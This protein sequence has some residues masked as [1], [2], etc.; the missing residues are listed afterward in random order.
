MKFKFL[1][2]TAL[3]TTLVACGGAEERKAVYMEKAK[4]SIETGDFDKARIELKNV[5][6]I[7]PKDGEAYYQLGRVFEKQKE[8]RKAY[9]NYLKA[10]ELVPELWEN[11]ARLGR[12][13]LLLMNDTAKAQEKVD[14]VLANDPGSPDGALLK[15]AILLRDKDTKQA[16]DIV[17]DVLDKNP[18]HIESVAFLASLY[19]SENNLKEAVDLLDASLKNNESNEMLNNLLAV[20]LLKNK[21]YER[22]EVLYKNAIKRNPDN[23]GNYNNLSDFYYLVSGDKVKAEE[24]LRASVEY[25]INDVERQLTLVKYITVVKSN[26]AAIDELNNLIARQKGIGKLRI[27]LI[28]LYLIEND[29]KSAIEVCDQAIADFSDEETGVNARIALASIYVSDKDY[30]KARDVIEAAMLISPNS[31]EINFIQAQLAV[32]DKDVEKAI[33]SL[34]I[35]IKEKPENIEA[36]ILLANVYQFEKND[37]QVTSVLNSAYDNNKTNADGLLKLAQHQLSRDIDITS[38]IIDDFNSIR[39][40]DHDGLSIKAGILNQK[41]KYADAFKIAEKLME[42]Y[43]EQPNG[44]LQAV[45]YYAQQGDKKKVVAVLEKGY[46]STKNNRKL[47]IVLTTI[48]MKSKEFDVVIER[49]EAEIKVAPDD[50][51]LKVLLAKVYLLSNKTSLAKALLNEI[52][53]MDDKL[54]TPYMLLSE[55]YQM[56]KNPE[57][58]KS[59]LVKGAANVPTSSIIPLKL[60]SIFELDGNFNDAIDI[61]YR[62]NQLKPDNLIVV[63]N[64]ASLLSDHGAGDAGLELAKSLIQKLKGSEQPAFLDTI[65][66]VYYRLGDAEK[67]IHNLKQAVEKQPDVNVFNYHLGMAYKLSGD[68]AQAKIYLEKSLVDKKYFIEKTS[69]ENALKSL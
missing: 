25:N 6:Q 54:E 47:L 1:L 34:R 39:E 28:Q 63:N 2:S 3:I 67:A 45:P 57:A 66:W 68:K 60:A 55:V 12:F 49:V 50:V 65:G 40:N 13:Y 61:F 35:V 64:L 30:D 22:V 26:S 59:I 38:K 31:P 33:I 53:S 36:Y 4:A 18:N 15:A 62:L 44:Y 14:L 41:K 69:A 5:L 17:K 19:G 23:K 46:L 37:E 20:V 56:E 32:R 48:Q 42:L 16:M 9:S 7:D 8:Y 51:E 52:I 11:H 43:P 21:E 29:K 24:V 10:A 58:V 27:A